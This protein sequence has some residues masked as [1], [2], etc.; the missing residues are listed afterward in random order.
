MNF[1]RFQVFEFHLNLIQLGRD[2]CHVL[3]CPYWFGR[4]T[5]LGRWILLDLGELDHPVP[6]HLSERIRVVW[7]RSNGGWERGGKAHRGLGFQRWP[8]AMCALEVVVSGVLVL[9][10]DDGVD[11]SVRLDEG[12]SGVWSGTSI[13]SYRGEEVWLETRQA[14]VSFMSCCRA[15][16]AIEEN[17]RRCWGGAHGHEEGIGIQER[18]RGYLDHARIGKICWQMGGAPMRDSGSLAASWAGKKREAEEGVVGGFCSGQNLERV[19][20][21][22]PHWQSE[23]RVRPVLA[24]GSCPGKKASLTGGATPSAR[25][26]GAAAYRFGEEGSW[27]MG[28]NRGRARLPPRGLFT[29]FCFFL[30]PFLFYLFFCNFFK[31]EK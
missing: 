17:Q 29:L 13:S 5:N 27:A 3:G 19:L 23:G 22:W 4:I 7:S 31:I 16:S 28:W 14:P 26:G 24:W 9:P 10:G 18:W 21:F 8:P 25:E 11:D 1:A 6:L 15:W 20:G 30:V 12:D 2:M